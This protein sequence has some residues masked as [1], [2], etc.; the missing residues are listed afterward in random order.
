[1]EGDDQDD[2]DADADAVRGGPNGRRCC[3]QAVSTAA[4]AGPHLPLDLLRPESSDTAIAPV[5]KNLVE[6]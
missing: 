2:A 4:H 5:R 1:M 3:L 6:S